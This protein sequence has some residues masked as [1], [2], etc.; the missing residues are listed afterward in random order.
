MATKP[1][2]PSKV[3]QEPFTPALV[4]VAVPNRFPLLVPKNVR[5]LPSPAH[6]PTIPVGDGAQGAPWVETDIAPKRRMRLKK[7]KHPRLRRQQRSTWFFGGKT[8]RERLNIK[9]LSVAYA[10]L[11][12]PAALVRSLLPLKYGKIMEQRSLSREKPWFG[13]MNYPENT[14]FQPRSRS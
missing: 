1:L 5:A 4:A 14:P 2:V 11:S 13:G 6:Q 8:T 7:D 12:L 3:K 10:K 9:S